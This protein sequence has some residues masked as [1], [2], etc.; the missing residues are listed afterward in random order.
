MSEVGDMSTI[1]QDKVK[2]KVYE[3]NIDERDVGSVEETVKQG[4]L[5]NDR[6]KLKQGLKERHIKMLTLVGVFGTGLFLS[7]G[8][9][10]KKTGP[11]GL[12]IAYLF[13][14][15]VVGCNQI[16]I[17]EVA[18]FMPA[19][20]ATIRHA[21]QFIDESVG[22]TFGWISTYS[23]LMP[24]ELSATAVIMT[25]WTDV[26]PAIFI[27]VF[28][29]LFVATNIYTIRFYGEIE[30]IFGWLKV[31]LII[32]LIVSGLVIDLGGTKGQERLGFHYWRDPGPF[33]NYLVGGHIGKFVGFWA[34][35]SSVVYSY[36][37][38][39]NIAILAGETKNSR[40][41]IFHGA[42]NVF[43][44]IIVLYLVTV[45]ILT[46]IVPYNDKL[47]A[48]GTGTARSSPFVIAMNRAGIKVLPHIVNALILTSA[49]SA[50][51]LAIIEG[52]R[53]LFCLATKN[54]APKIFLRTSKRGIPYVGVIFIS[55]FLPLAYMSCS[56]SSATVFGWFQE[57]VSSNTLLRWILISANH[58]HMD[59]A[60]KAQG[61]S[62]SDLPYSTRIG[63]FAAWF[64]GIMSFIFLL[65]GGFYNFIHGHFDIES[66]FTR[67]FIIPLAIGLFTFWKLLKKTR[68]LRPHEVDL[69]SIFEDIKENPEH[70][71]KSKL[72]WAKFSLK[73][74]LKKEE[75]V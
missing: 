34:A 6:T 18:S 1:S 32:I 27:T 46:L 42:K 13:V 26:S 5:H 49:W 64:S 38:I 14:G 47:I 22:F 58:I 20:G 75:K 16:A 72:I 39:Q 55:S 61:Y 30:Y 62:R 41:A 2:S 52:S 17:A 65:T 68:Y 66:F 19:T 59:R 35:I 43:L 56:K 10:L 21:E 40:H 73:K 12:L 67:Y 31:L 69:E 4:V 33:A 8:G 36:S 44:R 50:G 15:I 60:L 70:I 28:G 7:S 57:L 3:T 48:T 51:N 37:G 23:S 11:V 45:F 53:N 9:T 25:Y 74:G 71:E 63:P 24:G 54:Q 29:V